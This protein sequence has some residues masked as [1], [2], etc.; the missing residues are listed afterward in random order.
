MAEID[1]TFFQLLQVIVGWKK[2][3]FLF[4]FYSVAHKLQTGGVVDLQALLI[5]TKCKIDIKQ[6]RGILVLILTCGLY[7]IISDNFSN[8][9]IRLW[10]IIARLCHMLNLSTKNGLK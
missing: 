2:Y 5:G 3:F 6:C 9:E 7:G 4:F 8:L 1:F 10:S